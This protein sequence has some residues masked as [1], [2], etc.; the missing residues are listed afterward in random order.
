[1]L[2]SNEELTHGN[3]RMIAYAYTLVL[4]AVVVAASFGGL[5]LSFRIRDH[6]RRSPS[7]AETVTGKSSGLPSIASGAG[8]LL[9]VAPR[10]FQPAGE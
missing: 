2:P 3:G 6:R 1:V 10:D 4:E 7:V 5:W 8:L 9:D